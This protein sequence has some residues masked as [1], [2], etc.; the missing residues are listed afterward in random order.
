MLE[1][2]KHQKYSS[3]HLTHPLLQ[4]NGNGS[5]SLVNSAAQAVLLSIVYFFYYYTAFI[6]LGAVH[7][8]RST[9]DHMVSIWCMRFGFPFPEEKLLVQCCVL[10]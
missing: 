4:L 6:F 2:K 9:L 1:K 8:S 10:I 7:D 3:V 5:V